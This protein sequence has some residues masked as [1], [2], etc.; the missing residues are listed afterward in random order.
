MAISYYS[1][2]DKLDQIEAIREARIDDRTVILVKL[3]TPQPEPRNPQ[4]EK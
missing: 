1:P 4:H 3:D 2:S